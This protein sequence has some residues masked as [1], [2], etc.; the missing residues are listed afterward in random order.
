MATPVVTH[1]KVT[2]G[3]ADPS[4]SVDLADWDAQHVVTGLENVDNT[5]DANKPVSTAQAAADAVV[6]AD[7]AAALTAG[8]ANKVVGPASVTDDLP[9][10]FDGTTGK[11][12]KSKT[13]A[14]FKTLLALV[15][16][17]VGLGN[18]DNTS[19]ATKNAASVTLTNKIIAGADNTLTVRLANDVTG[20]LPVG[21]LNSGTSAS[22]S[23]FWR[24]DG[25]WAAA[26]GSG[27]VTSITGDG[28][29]ITTTG[30]LPPRFGFA[31][32]TIAVS[33][34][35]SAL[36]IALKDNAG[37][38]PSATSP[39]T[40]IFR[41]VTG[42]TGSWSQVSATGA[43]SLVVSSGSTLGVTSSTAFRLWVV[44]F[45]DGGTLRLGVVNCALTG[46]VFAL[47]ESIP[48]SSTAEGGAGGADSIG[49]FYT[50]T[51]VTSKSFVILGYI[52]W[53]A[54][55]LTA[56]TWTTTNLVSTQSFGPGVH[57]P[58][59]VVQRRFT[60]TSSATSTTSATF[61]T[62]N[63][64]ASIALTSAANYVQGIA[65]SDLYA[66]VVNISA[67]GSVHRDAT[68][69][70]V[71]VTGFSTTASPIAAAAWVFTDSPNS[72]SSIAYNVRL[73]TSSAGNSVTIAA[74]TG[75]VSYGAVLIEEI[76]R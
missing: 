48:A 62:T 39:A 58:G 12:I 5:S 18:V 8:L 42:A 36:T 30:T 3:P 7:A 9:A 67:I 69:L 55:G 47:T 60:T 70:N 10:I 17:D 74:T 13:Y 49:V 1:S 64:T 33:A 25:T 41:N 72:T 20:N 16:G 71:Q 22:S 21:N 19:D 54:S 11:L 40:F 46:G 68:N 14:A 34:A 52:E 59:E 35:A 73:R 32:A 31:N 27:T 26:P 38:D 56:G 66:S 44:M 37:S 2:G 51:A 43:M 6:A 15:K 53:N 65:N 23:T 50:G 57:K 4:V 45:N 61:V 76:M 24:G 28:L 63:L 75:G 29:A